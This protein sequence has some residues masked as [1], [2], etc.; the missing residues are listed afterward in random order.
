MNDTFEIV[1]DEFIRNGVSDLSLSLDQSLNSENN[2]SFRIMN[3]YILIVMKIYSL[4]LILKI[5]WRQ[6]LISQL[7]LYFIQKDFI[8]AT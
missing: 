3:P 7:I 6:I 2:I 1:A 8:F 4:E 5:T